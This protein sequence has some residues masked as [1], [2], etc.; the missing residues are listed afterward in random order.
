MT[1]GHK[2][3]PQGQQQGQASAQGQA[4]GQSTGPMSASSPEEAEAIKRSHWQACSCSQRHHVQRLPCC[5]DTFH[6]RTLIRSASTAK[7]LATTLL[8]QPATKYDPDD[9]QFVPVRR[10]ACCAM[11]H[12]TWRRRWASSRKTSA[13]PV[14]PSSR[15]AP[16]CSTSLQFSSN[17][18]IT[19]AP[20]VPALPMT[21]PLP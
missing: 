8:R 20:A 10:A 16:F 6:A 14:R 9:V 2:H 15:A 7:S 5:Q 21:C 11:R 12:R 18:A 13:L 4:A 1:W 3:K 19:P 17:A